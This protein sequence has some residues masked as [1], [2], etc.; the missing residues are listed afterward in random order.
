MYLEPRQFT[1]FGDIIQDQNEEV[2]EVFFIMKGKV[3]VGYNLLSKQFYGLAL[4]PRHVVNDYAMIRQRVS[5]YIYCP[6]LD[7]VEGLS[8]RKNNW[9]ML[10]E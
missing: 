3:G 10:F 2:H 4:Y 9:T 1:L 8:I 6:I 7:H 5:E